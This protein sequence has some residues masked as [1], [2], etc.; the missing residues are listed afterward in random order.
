M[1]PVSITFNGIAEW[2]EY[3]ERLEKASFQML[4]S[5]FQS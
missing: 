4:F 5:F 1:L 2:G 3:Q